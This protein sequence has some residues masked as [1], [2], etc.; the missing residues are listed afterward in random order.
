MLKGKTGKRE[1]EKNWKKQNQS[2][3]HQ[4]KE[5]FMK[6]STIRI[7]TW[8]GKVEYEKEWKEAE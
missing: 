4:S 3:I 6:K 2:F 8:Y 1:E 5:S 7:V